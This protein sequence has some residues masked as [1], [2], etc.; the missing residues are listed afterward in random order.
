MKLPASAFRKG[1]RF[2]RRNQLI[3]HSRDRPPLSSPPLHFNHSTNNPPFSFSSLSSPPIIYIRLA[4]SAAFSILHDHHAAYLLQCRPRSSCFLSAWGSYPHLSSTTHFLRRHT[5][6]HFSQRPTNQAYDR[7][8]RLVLATDSWLWPWR[9]T[10]GTRRTLTTLPLY[11]CA[12]DL[13]M[14]RGYH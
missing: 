3:C 10:A 5:K 13:N 8:C 11:A 7:S 1:K 12:A 4:F 6:L 2:A 9:E 14:A